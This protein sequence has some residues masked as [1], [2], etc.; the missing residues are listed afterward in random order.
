MNWLLFGYLMIGYS[1]AFN[2][3]MRAERNGKPFGL[4][5]TG[6][7]ILVNVFFWLPFQVSMSLL[8]TAL[9]IISKISS[10]KVEKSIK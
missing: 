6:I 1:M 3:C 2:S 10:K 4:A 8:E 7:V 9:I 5:E